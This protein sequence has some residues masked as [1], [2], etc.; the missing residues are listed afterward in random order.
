VSNHLHTGHP[1]ELLL[2]DKPIYEYP[3]LLSR[4]DRIG[5][6][7]TFR[8]RAQQL[9]SSLGHVIWRDGLSNYT[10]L[11]KVAARQTLP[12]ILTG[13]SKCNENIHIVK[14]VAN[15][16]SRLFRVQSTVIGS[17]RASA[18][19]KNPSEEGLVGLGSLWLG[20]T[21][22][23]AIELWQHPAQLD[24]ENFTLGKMDTGVSFET[25]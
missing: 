15:L 22:A 13:N 11:P 10:S 4:P 3:T 12:F 7:V 17:L 8:V 6:A 14:V 19:K 2:D 21:V 25:E 5:G 1:N 24:C 9:N 18:A 20:E 16:S 23:G